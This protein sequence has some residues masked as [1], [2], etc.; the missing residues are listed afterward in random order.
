MTERLA[1]WSRRAGTLIIYFP[2]GFLLAVVKEFVENL[3]EIFFFVLFKEK[4]S[5]PED[6][7]SIRPV[8]MYIQGEQPTLAKLKIIIMGHR[9][10]AGCNFF[11][12]L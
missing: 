6:M 12:V 1:G 5:F 11:F 3:N 9:G 10:V 8:E 2:R 7:V 4:L